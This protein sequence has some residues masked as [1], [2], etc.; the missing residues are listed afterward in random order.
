MTSTTELD[1][2]YRAWVKKL[3]DLADA[4][5]LSLVIDM[6]WK[7]E[8]DTG[9]SYVTM[10]SVPYLMFLTARTDHIEVFRGLGLVTGWFTIEQVESMH[11]TL[12]KYEIKLLV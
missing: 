5:D 9:R 6:S 11:S 10:R 1:R 7:T 2:K 4:H 12:W 8:T 3:S